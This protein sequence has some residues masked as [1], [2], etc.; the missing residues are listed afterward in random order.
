MALLLLY[1]IPDNGLGDFGIRT[2]EVFLF[3]Y[4]GYLVA[5]FLNKL[6]QALNS[7]SFLAISSEVENL[8]YAA[9]FLVFNLDL[10]AGDFLG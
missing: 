10:D 1:C 5:V 3:V 8:G 6:V 4:A 2:G 7:G 9:I